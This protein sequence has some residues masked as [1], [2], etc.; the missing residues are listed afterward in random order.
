MAQL[1]ESII[2]KAT[3]IAKSKKSVAM[4]NTIVPGGWARILEI[5]P[6]DDFFVVMPTNS[7]T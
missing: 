6:E 7:T 1:N 4:D 5:Y 3:K 2:K